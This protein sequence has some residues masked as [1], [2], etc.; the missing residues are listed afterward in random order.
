MK[1]GQT[2][3]QTTLITVDTG[4]IERPQKKKNLNLQVWDGDITSQ[5][6]GALYWA[7]NGDQEP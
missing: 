5:R 2:S 3:K 7:L 1:G 6:R 4:R